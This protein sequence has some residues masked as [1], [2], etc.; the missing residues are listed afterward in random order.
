MIAVRRTDNSHK[1]PNKEEF[2][3]TPAYAFLV[4]AFVFGFI[5]GLFVLSHFAR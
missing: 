5:I 1:K 4:T 3:S 2:N